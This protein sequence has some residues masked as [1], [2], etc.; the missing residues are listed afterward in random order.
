MPGDL[1]IIPL[2]EST[3]ADIEQQLPE[4]L[5]RGQLEWFD[6]SALRRRPLTILGLLRRRYEDAVLFAPDLEQPRLRLTS[7]LV[8]LPRARR[9]WR[10]DRAGRLESFST[11]EHLKAHGPA[12]LR[13]ILACG[14]AWLL[15][16]ALLPIAEGIL[17]PKAPRRGWRPRRVLYL[18]SQLWL[19]LQGGGSV[20]HTAGVIAGLRQA[21]VEVRVVSSDE[22]PG[23]SGPVELVRPEVWFDGAARE[24]EELVFNVPFLSAAWRVARQF[25]PD[26]IYQRHTAFGLAGAVLARLVRAPLVLEFNSSEVWKGRYWGGLHH[27]RRAER[28]ERLN[29]LAADRVVVVSSA[30]RDQLLGMQVPLGKI[31]VNPNG[32]DPTRFRPELAGTEVRRRFGLQGTVV[33]GFSGTFGKWHGIPTLAAVLPKV[34]SARPQARFLLL[35]DGALRPLVDEAV[36]RER[37][38]DRVVQPGL[39][40][41]AAMPDYLAACDI[42]ISPHGRQVDGREF[43]GSPTKLFEYMAAG[44]AIVASAVGQIA[45]VLVD[46]ESALLVPPDDPD[47]LARAIVRLVDDACLRVRL[48]QAV[49]ARVERDHTWLANAQRLL[50]S[51][52]GPAHSEP[53]EL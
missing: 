10:L 47:A 16:E 36:T 2:G 24:L 17:V 34:L 8:G 22:L 35:G 28:I 40:P 31:L 25:R 12:M 26:A 48:G 49:R 15:A 29:L 7:V 51:W 6:R 9:R 42:L 38:S 13:H 23:V 33:I 52:A 41:H 1:I 4:Q 5:R 44:R 30:L 32:V 19:G 21:G 43:F 27:V 3:P 53:V 18:R 14:L 37:L 46:G 20:A 45:D 50:D 11:F 39:V